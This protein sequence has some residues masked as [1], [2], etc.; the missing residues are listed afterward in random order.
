MHAPLAPLS[1]P[2]QLFAGITRY[3]EDALRFLD[4]LDAGAYV[5]HSLEALLR[6]GESRQ[7]VSEALSLC[8]QLPLLL[9][10]RLEGGVRERL[11]TA[12]LR[13]RGAGAAARIDEVVRLCRGSGYSHATPTSRPRGYPEEFL[14]RFAMPSDVVHLVLGRLRLED[15]Y[16]ATAHYPSPA[17]RG[18]ALAQQG[19]AVYL[20]LFLVPDVLH[21]DA[22]AM[23]ELVD[24]HFA[25][26]WVLPWAPGH[27]VDLTVAWEPYRSARAALDTAVPPAAAR[28][29]AERHAAAAKRLAGELPAFLAEGVLTEEFLLS[30]H[31]ALMTAVRDANVTVRWLLLHAA[32]PAAPPPTCGSAAPRAAQP[33]GR[34]AT[35]VASRAPPAEEVASLLLDT[36]ALEEALKKV[37]ERAVS[38]KDAAWE[39]AKEEAA[40]RIRELADFYSG[41]SVLSR[42]PRDDALRAWFAGLADA[43]GALRPERPV[44]TGRK[45]QQIVAALTEVEGFRA[46]DASLPTRAYLADTRAACARLLRLLHVGAGSLATLAVLADAGWAW[47]PA[48]A[49]TPR[50]RTRLAADPSAVHS[51]RCLFLKLRT[52]MELP[53]LRPGQAA[54]PDCFALSQFYSACLVDYATGVLQVVPA[55]MFHILTRTIAVHAGRLAELP[56]RLD[57]ATLREAAQLE[58]RYALAEATHAVAVFTQ[59][60][61]AMERTF[62]GVLELDPRRLLQDG[63]RGEVCAHVAA[64]CHEELRFTVAEAGYISTTVRPM[65]APEFEARLGALAARLGA[66]RAAFEYIQDYVN[67][68]GLRVWQEEMSRIAADAHAQERAAARAA[69]GA[70]AA[71]AAGA[72]GAGAAAAAAA[73]DEAAEE[74]G[75]SGDEADA[76]DAADAATA[77]AASGGGARGAVRVPRFPP[78]PPDD[79]STPT[80]LGRIARELLRHTAPVSTAYLPPLC[81]WFAPSPAGADA[82]TEAVGL[83]TFSALR[84]AVGLPGLAALDALLAA[85]LGAVLRHVG[86][87][88]RSRLAAGGADLLSAARRVLGPPGALPDVAPSFYTD[89][90]ARASRAVVWGPLLEALCTAGQLAL[91]R[92]QLAG[93]AARAAGADAAHLAA[94]AAA[95]GAGMAA[96]ARHAAAAARA[97]RRRAAAAAA[98]AAA[99]STPLAPPP[100]TPPPGPLARAPGLAADLASLQAA[101][102]QHDPLMACYNAPPSGSG[103]N[104][105]GGDG[106]VFGA[107]PLELDELPAL[108][109]FF[110]LSQLPRYVVDKRLGVLRPGRRHVGSAPDAAPL[111]AGAALLLRQA[112]PAASE[113]YLALL[114]Q[115][116]RV[117]AQVAAAAL[118]SDPAAA[119]TQPSE[120][121]AALAWCDALARVGG[122]PHAALRAHVPP[123]LLD[124]VV[125]AAPAPRR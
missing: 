65:T 40:G 69:A 92:K 7:L 3:H 76:A 91:L 28:R 121:V 12:H 114:G 35:S 43:L 122:V 24:R 52:M 89:A 26:A 14:A 64:A 87:H 66:L 72:A 5:A 84:A 54:S 48:H 39:G 10:A 97:A 15:I 29:L 1:P 21:S 56:T 31:E 13:F 124:T 36:A 49:L 33:P 80:W 85:R 125:A 60:M 99:T 16:G 30:N 102:G 27:A 55:T 108:L 51:L 103:H 95:A 82:A 93:E 18:A 2:S 90:C 81:A 41:S 88:Y 32:P 96:E 100:A 79:A 112:A 53:L 20:L 46:I 116:C 42:A 19:A 101:T 119:A 118:A 78:A 61:L 4:D 77:A 8:A 62:M 38:A 45:L 57:K 25:D 67:V 44:A 34:H 94:G 22:S 107:P 120:L 50:L 70:A 68:T 109:F 9:D 17:H 6:G 115:Y 86:A 98:L 110:T 58:E 106:G 37:A 117:Q 83:R 23:R 59:G 71:G 73:G 104:A 47:A 123:W 75:G 113:A 111:A 63:I 105:G 11:V 74:E